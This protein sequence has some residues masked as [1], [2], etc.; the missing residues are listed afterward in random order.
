MSKLIFSGAM[1][2]VD[3][4]Y[5]MTPFSD[6]PN[7]VI[8]LPPYFGI[9]SEWCVDK[10]SSLGVGEVFGG[11]RRR[12]RRNNVVQFRTLFLFCC[13]VVDGG[14]LQTSPDVVL[15]YARFVRNKL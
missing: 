2:I 15:Y 9:N 5:K 10:E 11:Y 7:P 6:Q 12:S 4:E 8:Y 3:S 14:G 1:Y 13:C